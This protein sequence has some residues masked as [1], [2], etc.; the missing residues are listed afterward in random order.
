[1]YLYFCLG[2][3]E[4]LMAAAAWSPRARF[5]VGFLPAQKEKKDKNASAAVGALYLLGG[6]VLTLL[7]QFIFLYWL[8]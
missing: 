2:A 3:W 6:Q 1:M 8:Y 7:H 5:G 4:E